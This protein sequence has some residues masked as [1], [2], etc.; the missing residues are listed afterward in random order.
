MVSE[1]VN[2]PQDNFAQEFSCPGLE[3]KQSRSASRRD[4]TEFSEMSKKQLLA[5][6]R[7]LKLQSLLSNEQRPKEQGKQLHIGV[8]YA[9]PIIFKDFDENK[10]RGYQAMPQNNF[11]D[12]MKAIKSVMKESG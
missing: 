8:L 5:E 11:L 12:E 1:S 3:V 9:S 6:L 10:K 4:S 7:R 2:Q